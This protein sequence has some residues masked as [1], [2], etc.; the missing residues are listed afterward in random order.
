M[1]VE[2]GYRDQ[3]DWKINGKV[4]HLGQPAFDDYVQKQIDTLVRSLG[5]G[6]TKILFL[7][8]PYTHPANLPNGSPAPAASPARHALINSM[9]EAAARRHPG[10][11][12]VLDLDQTVSPGNHYDAN[13]NG[14]LCRFDG[15]HFSAYCSDLLEPRVLGEVRNLLGRA[16]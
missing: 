9:L 6:G 15:V 13:V 8:I 12:D 3:F 16:R 11:V 1:V 5:A 4:V 10:T 14:Q 7:S 2:L